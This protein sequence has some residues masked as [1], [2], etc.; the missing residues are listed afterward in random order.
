ML[1]RLAITT[2]A[3]GAIAIAGATAAFATPS[4]NG[5]GQPN[6]SCETPGFSAPNGFATDGFAHAQ[7]V[8]AG[9]GQ[10]AHANSTH[11]VSQYDVACFQL[12]TP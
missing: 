4:T 10:S 6:Q 11:A 8:Y 7:T 3:A 9:A 5:P 1:K 2:F 12:S